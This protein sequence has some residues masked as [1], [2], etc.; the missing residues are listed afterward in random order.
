MNFQ[1]LLSKYPAKVL[2][3][4]SLS[5]AVATAV[6]E[7]ASAQT[8]TLTTCIGGPAAVPGLTGAPNW[9]GSEPASSTN[10]SG[11]RLD[12]D[13]PRWASAPLMPFDGTMTS[14]SPTYRILKYENY[15]YVSFHAPV[16][17]TGTDAIFFGFSEGP[18]STK[19][20]YL[21]EIHPALAE[22]ASDPL[23][24]PV[25]HIQIFTPG[26]GGGWNEASTPGWLQ[27][28]KTWRSAETGLA[29]GVNFRI[30]YKTTGTSDNSSAATAK[31]VLPRTQTFRTFFGMGIKVEPEFTLEYTT[32][33]FSSLL[34][35]FVNT[36]IHVPADIAHWAQYDGVS[37]ACREGVT[38][39]PY[40]I[41]TGHPNGCSLYTGD[42]VTQ[43][44]FT[45]EPQ[46]I[47]GKM[48][49]F[50]PDVVRV[51]LSLAEWGGLFADSQANWRV[52][53]GTNG[54]T[55]SSGSW[56][57]T[58]NPLPT[59][60]APDTFGSANIG[61]TCA[62]L[63]NA[64]CPTLNLSDPGSVTPPEVV[65]Q[66]L[67]ATLSL[68][69]N[70]TNS[71]PLR[72]K[73]GAAYMNMIP[74]GLSEATKK[75]SISLRGTP[76]PKDA[77]VKQ[78]DV[79]LRVVRRNMPPHADAMLVPPLDET[80]RIARFLRTPGP[81]PF[82]LL[83]FEGEPEP[84]G[85]VPAGKGAVA[86]QKAAAPASANYGKPQKP[87]DVPP[88]NPKEPPSRQKEPGTSLPYPLPFEYSSASNHEL[89]SRS[90][91]VYEVHSYYDTGETVPDG[92]GKRRKVLR[93]LAPFGYVLSHN[94]PFYGFSARMRGVG[95]SLN[96][97]QPDVYKV[98]VP[99]DGSVQ[100]ETTIRAEEKPLHA[101]CCNQKPPIVHVHVNPRGCYCAAPGSGGDGSKLLPLAVLPAAL[102]IWRRKRR[103]RA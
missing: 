48:P 10:T 76:K 79:Y 57:W 56:S 3:S 61:F 94:A 70:T 31:V 82:Q 55:M 58:W 101:N 51:Q 98:S 73:R 29:F 52:I 81:S 63:G 65:N 60:P 47:R 100:I 71:G 45:V 1:R 90:L 89:V 41:H 30:A 77:N 88:P 25:G 40:N 95:C 92:K 34:T 44:T 87:G 99:V 46:N 35:D 9:F 75:A 103:P 6:S 22:G 28:V 102:L 42:P 86:Q 18:A 93:A 37:S 62:L 19:P 32:P 33:T 20:A 14:G 16:G 68:D 49:Q 11:S 97:V 12:I 80:R 64:Y 54:G 5:C 96:E 43:N 85:Y 7:S 53:D 39:D 17:S 2:I 67:L 74:L 69:P 38:I 15:L 23:P 8:S 13:E 78:R 72:I 84:T 83:P 4:T 91:P 26:V 66:A 27:D 36:G 24:T 50:A 21:I 59:G